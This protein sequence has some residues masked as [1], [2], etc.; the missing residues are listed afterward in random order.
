MT[1]KSRPIHRRRTVP[2]RT[3][4]KVLISLLIAALPVLVIGGFFALGVG[5]SQLR[6]SFSQQMAQVAE[7]TAAGVDSYVF[8]RMR[9]VSLLAKVPD[10]RQAAVAGSGEPWDPE[11]VRELDQVWQAEQGPPPRLADLLEQP[12]SRFLRE[13]ASDDPIYREILLTDRYGRLVAA[14][15]I[16]SDYFQ[17]DEEWWRTSYDGGLIGR[18]TISDLQWDE[19]A[20]VFSV[21]ITV[22]VIDP[23]EDRLVGILR[24]VSDSREMFAAIAGASASGVE[25][26]LLRDDGSVVF[27]PRTADPTIT[28]FFAADLLRERLQAVQ[29]GDPQY[30]VAFSARGSDGTSQLVALAPTQLGT[31]FPNL[32]WL[33]AVSQPETELFSPI[34]AQA[35][36]LLLV[37]AVTA[38][39][40]LALGAWFSFHLTAPL[41]EED[42]AM[43]LVE[44]PETPRLVFCYISAAGAEISGQ[45]R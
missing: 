24:V 15:G 45:S 41:E 27:S 9:D 10:V 42:V 26:V 34:Q 28:Q 1:P 4:Q 22:P 21:D 8:R 44:H 6:A 32:P 14:S 38:L 13:I 3:S 23:S 29:E 35:T 17:A 31:S 25:A 30:R 40:V 19:S 12:A 36:N 20:Q 16:T 7:R 33:V 2:I 18:V 39:L 43:H 11:A 5:Q 37:L